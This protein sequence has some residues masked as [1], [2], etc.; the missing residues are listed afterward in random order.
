MYHHNKNL[1]ALGQHPE[2]ESYLGQMEFLFLFFRGICV[3]VVL[4][5]GV[6]SEW[7]PEKQGALCCPPPPG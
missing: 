1:I 5:H 3:V 6:L 2:E 4:V 7:D